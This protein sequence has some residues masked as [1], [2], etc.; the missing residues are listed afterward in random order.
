MFKA[1]KQNGNIAEPLAVAVDGERNFVGRMVIILTYTGAWRVVCR[2]NISE[3][4]QNFKEKKCRSENAN[5]ADFMTTQR[6]N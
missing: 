1:H 2:I 5:E 3:T 4:T 6:T